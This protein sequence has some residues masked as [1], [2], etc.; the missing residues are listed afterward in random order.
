VQACHVRVEHAGAAAVE[1]ER[2]G[3]HFSEFRPERRCIG[4]HERLEGLSQAVDDQGRAFPVVV[5]AQRREH[6]DHR[7]TLPMPTPILQEM[8]PIGLRTPAL[9]PMRPTITRTAGVPSLIGVSPIGHH[10]NVGW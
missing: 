10:V 7:V 1:G 5:G 4:M 9:S 3:R 2:I 8:P 6:V